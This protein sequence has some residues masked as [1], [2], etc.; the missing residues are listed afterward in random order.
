MNKKKPSCKTMNKIAEKFIKKLEN[1]EYPFNP[2]TGQNRLSGFFLPANALN[3]N[4]YSGRNRAKLTFVGSMLG[5]L[6][7]RWCTFNQARS[8][9]WKIN[10]GEVATKILYP[11][12]LGD[13]DRTLGVDQ[14]KKL[15]ESEK[16]DFNGKYSERFRYRSINVFN[17]SQMSKTKAFSEKEFVKLKFD[18]K[19]LKE[20]TDELIKNMKI[21]VVHSPGNATPIYKSNEDMVRM[22]NKEAYPDYRYYYGTLLHELTHATLHQSRLDREIGKQ[23]YVDIQDR[24]KEEFVAEMNSYILSVQLGVQLEEKHTASAMTYCGSW[25][26]LIKEN[27]EG[28]L[29]DVVDE[30]GKINAYMLREGGYK[31]YIAKETVKDIEEEI[32][33]IPEEDWDLEM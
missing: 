5:G 19:T 2:E 15:S 13:K 7:P 10:K 17:L 11:Y 32:E 14:Y 9:G 18:E 8:Q 33:D 29:S 26:S 28:F 3:K 12:Y 20:F 1:K 31:K 24:A 23:G 27:P 22:P 16:A 30:V 6:E 21:E 4:A 25:H